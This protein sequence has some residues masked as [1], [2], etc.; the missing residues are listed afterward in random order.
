MWK[1]LRAYLVQI[2]AQLLEQGG[3]YPWE[4]RIREHLVQIRFFQHER[5]VHLLVTLAFAMF[6]VVSLLAACITG[7]ALLY[8]LLLALLLLLVPY[9]VHYYHLENGVQRLYR[10]YDGLAARA[11]AQA[12]GT[13]TAAGGSMSGVCPTRSRPGNGERACNTIGEK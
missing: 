13:E 1:R 9:I 2:D 10:Q 6:A 3:P 4:E 11:R 8:L 12:G 5:A 7:E